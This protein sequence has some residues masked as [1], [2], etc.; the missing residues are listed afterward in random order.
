MSDPLSFQRVRSEL[1]DYGIYVV[2]D[3]AR[4]VWGAKCR[5][6]GQEG[7]VKTDRVHPTEMV[8][9]QFRHKWDVS[10][11]HAPVHMACKATERQEK[12]LASEKLGPDP[13][14]ARR[15]YAKLD[16]VFD[17][18]KRIYQPGWND[19]K[20]AADLNVSMQIVENIRR[21][22]YGELAEQPEVTAAKFEITK[23]RADM[24]KTESELVDFIQQSL[25]PFRE[26]IVQ[27]EATLIK[28]GVQHHKAAG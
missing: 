26:R 1:E 21:E 24:E 7:T 16:E 20:V 15:I 23:L 25:Q 19:T 28:T 5:C 18:R 4:V 22:A 2:L 3:Q 10:R 6:C 27:L 11:R 14:L 12:K 13:K 17:E 8:I 9:Q